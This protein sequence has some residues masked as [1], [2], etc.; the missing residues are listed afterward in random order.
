[1]IIFINK[2]FVGL[3]R[4]IE[5]KI[6][7]NTIY[8]ILIISTFLLT[9]ITFIFLKRQ[10]FIPNSI[11]SNF[12]EI[13]VWILPVLIIFFLSIY[14]I[15]SSFYI[16]PLKN[17]YKNIKPLIIEI[18]SL[19]WKWIIIYPKQKI[20]LLNE[21]C[22]PLLI[23][24]KIEIISNSLMN[25]LCIP[26]IGLQM[27][28]MSNYKKLE[29]LIIIKHGIMHGISSNFNGIGYSHMKICLFSIIKK[30]FF[31]W[32]NNIK[33]KNFFFKTKNYNYLSKQSFINNSKFFS[34]YNNKLFFLILKYKKK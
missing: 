7:L 6:L 17:V 24:I 9:I 18:I 31:Y 27:Y 28:C 3:E 11:N 29:N 30:N 8:L 13:I 32:I 23:P 12:I 15:K 10:I 21:M 1:M 5:N 33:K 4:I 19:N 20:L 2:H 14:T 22:I 34:I 16:N 25:T 26:K